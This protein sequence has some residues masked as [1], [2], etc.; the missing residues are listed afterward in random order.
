CLCLLK[1]SSHSRNAVLLLLNADTQERGRLVNSVIIYM[2][3]CSYHS[4]LHPMQTGPHTHTQTHTHT[5][6]HTYIIPHNTRHTYFEYTP[7]THTRTHTHTHT[8]TRR[9][10]SL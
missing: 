5:H 10:A 2:A 9:S 7:F 1:S 3:S 4:P 6:T 8:H